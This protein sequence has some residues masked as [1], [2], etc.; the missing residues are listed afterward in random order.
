M[1][2]G[3]FKKFAKEIARAGYFF[4]DKRINGVGKVEKAV[5]LLPDINKRAVDGWQNR[6]DFPLVNITEDG[7]TAVYFD[8][9][10]IEFA[11]R[12][13]GNTTFPLLDMN[14]YLFRQLSKHLQMFC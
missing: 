6:F 1:F 13:N 2:F 3:F 8:E 14:E 12:K 5:S 10:I 11:I 7:I 4:L 9:E